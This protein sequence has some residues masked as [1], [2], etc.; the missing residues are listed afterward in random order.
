LL[1]QLTGE[2]SSGF[3][4]AAKPMTEIYLSTR[5]NQSLATLV[6]TM[7]RNVGPS[8][9]AGY[10]LHRKQL[11]TEKYR[12]RFHMLWNLVEPFLLG[13]IF[14]ALYQYRAISPLESGM[15][16]SLFVISG[17]MF[18]QCLMD[19]F[20]VP[21]GQI[22]RSKELLSNTKIKPEALMWSAIIRVFYNSTFRLIIVLLFFYVFNSFDFVNVALAIIFFYF[23]IFLTCALGF[24]FEPFNAVMEDFSKFINLLLR[25]LMFLSGVIFP[26]KDIEAI[27]LLN[28][29]NFLFLIIEN[30]R[31]LLL[32]EAL[33]RTGGLCL[34][35]G[36]LAAT[37]LFAWYVFHISVRL[38]V[39]KG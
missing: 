19:G 29:Y 6:K 36:I 9:H 8:F 12:S 39:E 2:R 15:P 30:F 14:V 28:Q 24:L 27:A 31:A 5:D 11:A 1:A 23:S 38:V 18:W 3:Y 32:G 10:H 17:V 25:P 26:V 7:V 13:L 16:Y 37:F 21:L 20:N 34:I 33:Y 35:V 22:G 4:A